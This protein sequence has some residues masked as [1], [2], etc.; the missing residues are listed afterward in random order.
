MAYIYGALNLLRSRLV[1]VC[2]G[3]SLLAIGTLRSTTQLAND[4][5]FKKLKSNLNRPFA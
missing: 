4:A 5:A 3:V 2:E 1:V